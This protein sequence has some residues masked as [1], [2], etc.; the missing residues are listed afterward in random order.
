MA[1]KDLVPWKKNQDSV[2]DRRLQEEDTLLDLR[3]QLNR[4]FDEFLE[5]PF[6]LSPFFDE[7][8][9]M[10]DFAPCLD[11]SETEKEIT[12]SADLPGMDP[13]DIQITLDRDIL[14]IRGEKRAEK[15]DKGER[16]Y[17][18]ERYF[19]FF[20]RSIP[21]PSEVDEKKIDATFGRGVLKVNLSKTQA[22]QAKSKRIAI[23]TG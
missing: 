7:S 20:H 3:S 11:I 4:L 5:Q 15:T 18:S 8:T 17:Q 1:I 22:A 10:G 21:L 12:I 19:G 9:M 13:E 6:G 16:F 14:T 23:K 2:P